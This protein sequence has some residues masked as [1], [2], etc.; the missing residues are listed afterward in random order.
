[1]A[2]QSTVPP[3][4]AAPGARELRGVVEDLRAWSL[5]W[6]PEMGEEDL[7]PHLLFW[8]LQRRILLDSWPRTRTV[9]SFRLTRV[10]L[11]TVGWWLVVDGDHVDVCDFGPGFEVAATLSASLR[12]LIQV[13]RGDQTWEQA[14]GTGAVAVAAPPHVRRDLPEWLES[15]GR[16]TWR[17]PEKRADASAIPRTPS[18]LGVVVDDPGRDAVH[19]TRGPRGHQDTV[20]QE[21][22]QMP[23]QSIFGMIAKLF[24]GPS[25]E[26][27]ASF[28]SRTLV[29]RSWC[30]G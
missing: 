8:D 13:W 5:R 14:V 28:R 11:R 23:R 15:V 3:P 9:V 2:G 27:T 12:S 19:R 16:R 22:R 18:D 29:D 24:R 10:D 6:I 30:S 4:G 26:S 1:M 25:G 17:S 7:D 21:I 20:Q